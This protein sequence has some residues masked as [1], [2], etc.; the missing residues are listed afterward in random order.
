MFAR[1]SRSVSLK[2][3]RMTSQATAGF[4]NLRTAKWRTGKMRTAGAKGWPRFRATRFRASQFSANGVAGVAVVAKFF[5]QIV[6]VNNVSVC[7]YGK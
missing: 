5:C 2:P 7:S 4:G 1:Q 3:D 6:Y